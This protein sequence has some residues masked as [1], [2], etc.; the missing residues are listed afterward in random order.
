MKKLF[1]LLIVCLFPIQG[2]AASLEEE[3]EIKQ[4][5]MED[6]QDLFNKETGK[7]KL[8]HI[9]MRNITYYNK[10]L[11]SCFMMIQLSTDIASL[12]SPRDEILSYDFYHVD[13]NA[14]IG[15]FLM[16]RDRKSG[17]ETLFYCHFSGRECHSLP[18][19][20]NL[21]KSYMEE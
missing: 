7:L 5:C 13:E 1:A 11:K 12:D 8:D 2:G 4:L 19:W 3:H 18:E 20:R 6:A 15:S 10:S 17:R 16:Q 14:K 9:T 21:V